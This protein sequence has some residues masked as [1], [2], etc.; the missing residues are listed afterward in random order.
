VK[1]YL[2]AVV[3]DNTIR[4][5]SDMYSSDRFKLQGTHVVLVGIVNWM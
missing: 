5:L 3:D 1:E 4:D 2:R